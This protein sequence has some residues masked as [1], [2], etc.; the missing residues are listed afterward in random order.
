MTNSTFWSLKYGNFGSFIPKN[1]FSQI[2][3]LFPLPSGEFSLEKKTLV[4]TS[5]ITNNFCHK[6][7]ITW[8]FIC[9]FSFVFTIPPLSL[10]SSSK[11]KTP[12]RRRFKVQVP[13]PFKINLLW[14][15]DYNLRIPWNKWWVL[16]SHIG[17][18]GIIYTYL[19]IVRFKTIMN[20]LLM[21]HHFI[22]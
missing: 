11:N 20:C 8:N 2:T 13:R 15:F 14:T 7:I 12:Q 10:E 22:S 1:H 6:W 17:F 9:N 3:I 21:N 4:V 19:F 5:I 16:F 18:V